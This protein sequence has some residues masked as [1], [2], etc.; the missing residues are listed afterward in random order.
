MDRMVR[1]DAF[2]ENWRAAR[3][4]A[5]QAVE[6]MPAGKLD[7]RPQDDL[8]SF[9]ETAVHIVQ[10]GAALTGLMLDREV[11]L[12]TPDL[13]QKL[14][15]YARPI[16]D[17]AGGSQIAAAMR[18]AVEEHCAALARREPEFFGEMVIKWDGT[19]LTRLEMMQFIKEHEIAHRM[20]LFMYLRLN[21]V[22][23][24]TTRRKMARS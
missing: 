21:G 6:D 7:Y 3:E 19:R 2:L 24:P 17:G 9:R 14:E 8:M 11:D 12:S 20:Q 5:A 13:R 23:P 22:V 16:P 4:D 1:V 10:A 15:K 18:E